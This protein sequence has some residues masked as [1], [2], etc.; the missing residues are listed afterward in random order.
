MTIIRRGSKQVRESQR[1]HEHAWKMLDVIVE[2]WENAKKRRRENA[3]K[4]VEQKIVLDVT[5]NLI[6][7][8]HKSL[9]DIAQDL[10]HN[11]WQ[12]MKDMMRTI[13]ELEPEE[14]EEVQ[15]SDEKMSIHAI[16]HDLQISHHIVE[17][18]E[19]MEPEGWKHL[20]G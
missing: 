19:I 12:M 14:E 4:Q 7:G 20:E 8:H 13:T 1:E 3:P 11:M 10:N 17:Q 16:K 6:S 18:L 9:L 15:E 5:R 2:V